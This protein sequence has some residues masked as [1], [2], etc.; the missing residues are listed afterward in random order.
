M[1]GQLVSQP[2]VGR[3]YRVEVTCIVTETYVVRADSVEHAETRANELWLDPAEDPNGS[4]DY[5]DRTTEVVY[6]PVEQDVE[7]EAR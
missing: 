5:R 2:S 3:V 4:I 6:G 7:F 1:V